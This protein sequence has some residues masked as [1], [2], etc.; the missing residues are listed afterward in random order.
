MRGTKVPH[1]SCGGRSG[2]RGQQGVQQD[3]LRGARG[4]PAHLHPEAAVELRIFIREFRFCRGQPVFL[5]VLGA[6]RF[7][8]LCVGASLSL[9]F[10]GIFNFFFVVHSLSLE[11]LTLF[12]HTQFFLYFLLCIRLSVSLRVGIV[13][14]PLLSRY[15]TYKM[16][17][18]YDGSIAIS[19]GFSYG[20]I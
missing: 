2:R 14:I 19:D 15:V 12:S 13:F 3:L 1:A 18:T 16:T 10:R 8:L 7:F 6:R 4:T 17:H 11:I 5:A 20:I 9:L